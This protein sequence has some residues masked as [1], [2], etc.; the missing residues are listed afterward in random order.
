MKNTKSKFK[1]SDVVSASRG[2]SIST[3]KWCPK[4]KTPFNDP[5]VLASDD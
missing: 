5:A 4:I 3:G 2:D 1:R